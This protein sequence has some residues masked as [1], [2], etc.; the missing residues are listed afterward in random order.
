MPSFEEV[1]ENKTAFA[2]AFAASYKEQDYIRGKVLI[3]R[4]GD[5]YLVQNPPAEPLSEMEFDDIYALPFTREAHPSYEKRDSGAARSEVLPGFQP[6]M[7]W[8]VRILRDFLSSGRYIQSR[9][10]KSLVEEAEQLAQRKDFKGYI[11]DVGGPT[12]NFTRLSCK[13]QRSGYVR[14]AAVPV[15][16]ALP[17]LNRGSQQIFGELA[18]AAQR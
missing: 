17:E 12:A 1:A 9:S 13:R 16:Q 3:Q 6:G 14:R 18:G 2:K 7:L 11:H 8:R 5:R 15:A 4:H 10:T